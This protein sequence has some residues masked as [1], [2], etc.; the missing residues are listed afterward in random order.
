M[1]HPPALPLVVS[2]VARSG[3]G[4]TTFLEH[5][6]PVL[7]ALEL[8]VGVL[9]HHAHATPFDVPGKDTSR[10]S[11]AGAEVVV[12]ASSVQTAV[13]IAGNA[14]DDIDAVI[15][16]YLGAMDLVLTDGYKRGEYPKI[17]I[18][19]AARAAADGEAG[20]LLCAPSE[21]LAVVTDEALALPD[22][23]PQFDRDDVQGVA[24]LIRRRMAGRK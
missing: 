8:R 4:K 11:Q 21:L 3:S 9:K 2:I 24:Q 10:L 1:A 14:T 20:Q 16:R 23:I 13:F 12:G 7:K 17:E 6:V 5:L 18:H 19:R 22:T 15:R